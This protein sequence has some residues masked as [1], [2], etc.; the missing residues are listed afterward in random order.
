LPRHPYGSIN[1]IEQRAPNA[2][3]VF[4]KSH[5]IRHL[6]DAVDQV[7][8]EK[9]REKGKEHKELFSAHATSG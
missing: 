7:R 3:L 8:R 5:I 9:I 4:D 2:V 6:M 1:V